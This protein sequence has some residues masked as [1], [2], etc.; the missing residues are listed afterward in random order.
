MYILHMSL[1]CGHLDI[2][3]LDNIACVV[4]DHI[5]HAYIYWLCEWSIH[6]LYEGVNLSPTCIGTYILLTSF[7]FIQ[8]LMSILLA[9]NVTWE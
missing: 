1:L 5:L 4:Q 7:G 2:A 3:M 8:I 6:V 9:L